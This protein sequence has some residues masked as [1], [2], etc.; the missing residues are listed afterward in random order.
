MLPTLIH[1]LIAGALASP[2]SDPI[3]A[4]AAL[5]ALVGGSA[6]ELDPVAEEVPTAPGFVATAPGSAAPVTATDPPV[7]SPAS[8]I[9]KG[10]E[11]AQ[12]V[13][14]PPQATAP[15]PARPPQPAQ[16][17]MPAAPPPPPPGPP[18]SNLLPPSDTQPP[19][20][21]SALEQ[22]ARWRPRF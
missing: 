21:D 15:Q 19:A 17:A 14:Q 3:S 18:P 9:A 4:A 7:T 6:V 8:P 2:A 13:T 12:P 16:P 10:P 22:G 5:P 1:A 20:P 11:T